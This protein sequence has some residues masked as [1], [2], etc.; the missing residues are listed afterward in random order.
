MGFRMTSASSR[1]VFLFVVQQGEFFLRRLGRLVATF[2]SKICLAVLRA[3][4]AGI[5]FTTSAMVMLHYLGV[6]MPGPSELLEKFEDLGRL[7]RI[8]S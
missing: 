4:V 8:L 2:L 7:A 5:V 1:A 3:I 6:P